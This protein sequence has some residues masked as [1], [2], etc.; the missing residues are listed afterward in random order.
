MSEPARTAPGRPD[1]GAAAGAAAPAAGLAGRRR[2]RGDRRRVASVSPSSFVVD[3]EQR[4]AR[5]LAGAGAARPR[6]GARLLGPRP[7]RRRGHQRPYPVPHDDAEG[8]AALGDELDQNAGSSRGAASCEIPRLRRRRLRPQPGRPPRG[9]GPVAG[10]SLFVTA[11]RP[12]RRLVT[13]DGEPVTRDVLA[14]GGFLVAFPEGTPRRPTPRSR[15]PL[16]RRRVQAAA[17]AR[18]LEPRG[19]RRLLARLHARR[20]R[21][22]PVPGRGAGAG[23]PVPPVDLRPA[24][25]RAAGVGPAGRPLPQLPLA[26]DADGYLVAQSDF[27]EPVGPGFWDAG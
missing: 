14:G 22:G 7:G 16:R 9:A 20:L 5:R 26:I 12:G 19:L 25:R 8:Q 24:R 2:A 17:R 15:S 13:I 6:H 11:W 4:L 23:L 18:D 1:G 27:T 10:R 3:A 21:R